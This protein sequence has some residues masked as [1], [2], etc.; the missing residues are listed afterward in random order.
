MLLVTLTPRDAQG[1]LLYACRAISVLLNGTKFHLAGA[2]NTSVPIVVNNLGNGSYTATVRLTKSGVNTISA[3][4]DNTDP[5]PITFDQTRNIYV[6]PAPT[7]HYTLNAPTNIT[8]GGTRAA[9]TVSRYDVYNNLKT[10]GAETVYLTSTSDGANKGFYLEQTNGTAVQSITIADGYASANFWYYDEKAG[11]WTISASDATPENGATGII[12]AIDVLTV[13]PAPVHHLALNAPDDITAGSVT[14]A[15]YTVTLQDVYNNTTA[16]SGSATTVSLISSSTGANKKFYTAASGGNTITQVSLAAGVSSANFWYYDEKAGD[17]RITASTVDMNDGIDEITVKPDLLKNF[18]VSGVSDPHDLGV[19]Q[20]VTVEA[21]DTYDNRK[22][23]YVGTIMFGSSD[24]HAKKPAQ[25]QFPEAD[26]G[27]HTFDNQVEFSQPGEFYLKAW[28]I[29]ESP[30]YGFQYNITVQR[31][32]TVTANARMK[33]YGDALNLGTTE[34]AVTGTNYTDVNN[35]SVNPVISGDITGVSLTSSGA[36]ATANAGT[37]TITSSGAT[38][39]SG[40]NPDYYHVTYVDG[41]LTVN[42]KALTV[43][44]PIIASRDYDATR[45]AGTVTVGILSGFVAGETVTATA[46]ATDYSSANAGTYNNVVVNYTLTDG[47]NGG[48]AANYSLANGTATG[49]INPRALTA[50]STVADKTYDGLKATGT[51]SLGA[52][53]N[54]V[55]GEDLVITPSASDF[56]DAN[57]ADGKATTITYTLANGANG[58]AANYS[59]ST[60]AATGDINPRALTAAS[61]VADKTYDGLKATGTVSLGVVS[62]MVEG[63]DLVI[64]PL[65]SDFADANAA[66]GKATTITYTLANGA[67]GLA[68]NYSMSTFAATGD[69]NPRALTAASTVADK[70]YDGLK[71]TGTVSLGVVSNMVEGEDLVITPLSSDFADANAADGKATTITYTLANGANGLAAN[72]SMSTFAT[73][74]DINPRALTAA[75]TVADKT[76]DGSPVTGVVTLGTVSNLVD[77]EALVITPTAS[78]F[79]DANAADGKATTITYT[80]ADG[81]NGLA[82]NYSMSTFAATGDI[83]PRALTAASTVADKTYDGLKA[84][85]TVSLGV[86]SNMVEGEDLVITPLS[87]DFADANAA[88]GKATTITYTLANG[89]NGLAANYSMSTFAATGD[90]NP[91]A[92]TAA[93]TVADKTYDGLKATG[94][95]SLGAVSNMVEGEDLV[96]TPLSSDFADANAADG[97]A[98]TITYTLADGTNGLAANYSMSTFAATGDINPRALT[99]ASTVADKTYDGLKA[100]GT[101]SLGVVSNMVEGEDLVITPLSSDF[102]DANAADGKATTI[103]Y[104]LANGANGLA[105]NY[106]MSTFAATGDINPRALTAASTVADKTYDGLKATG[107]V[108]LGVVSNMV[109]GEDLVITPLSSDFAD[110]NA[111]DGKAT[112]ITYTLANGANGLAA[113]YS[114]STFA[115]T[116]DINPRALTAATTVAD[117]TYDGSPVTGVVTLGNCFNPS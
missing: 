17:H 100:T 20:S 58:L 84:T 62:N 59:M 57:A 92:L 97:K 75:T 105:A 18:V 31:A 49:D 34:F 113:N 5:D 37:Y 12:D 7:H 56:A 90:I 21:L 91:R 93:S 94:T 48:L 52:V 35:A 41:T 2:N 83:N 33:T 30:K 54:M 104:T 4:Y 15:A 108:S 103:T 98:T 44:A 60:F 39:K 111:A 27:V 22:T 71:A 55:E 3:T 110:A 101:V 24:L 66:D 115:T 70:T 63:E 29:D 36:V 64:T 40:V 45:T 67:N 19:L 73:T 32:V 99:A 112:T 46:L 82:A 51:V 107:T 117:K 102:A 8:A 25:Y 74:G 80:L 116:G 23:D 79:A 81:T 10:E 1:N 68:A 77:G 96:I 11:N 16:I 6:T 89:A 9:F 42:K 50:A 13:N 95:V 106:S 78:D 28:D 69:I 65:S 72:Y 43:T 53:S 88:D 14:R 109:E 87:S 86:V 61:T 47:T 85:G 76:Y 38:F 26:K 114:M